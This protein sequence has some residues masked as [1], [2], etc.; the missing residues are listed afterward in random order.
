VAPLDVR[1]PD[2]DEA[3]K[4]VAKVVQPNI[5]V[6]RDPFKLDER[7]CRGAPS[8]VIEVLSPASAG[9]DQVRKLALYERHGIREYWLAHPD[10]RIVTVCRLDRGT[11]GR[12]LMMG[13]TAAVASTAC[14]Q[15]AVGWVRVVKGLPGPDPGTNPASG[16]GRARRDLSCRAGRRT[17]CRLRIPLRLHTL[18]RC[19]D[20]PGPDAPGH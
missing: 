3:D 16:R 1:L 15:V 13:C 5:T 17:S 2:D 14:P 12:P 4:A 20:G 6:V 19:R 11:Y 10:D 8:R 18:H 9:Q 7:G